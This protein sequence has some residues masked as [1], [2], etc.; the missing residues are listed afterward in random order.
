MKSIFIVRLKG[1]I[2]NQLF[3][4]SS[5]SSLALANDAFIIIDKDSGFLNDKYSR[6]YSI[7]SFISSSTFILPKYIAYLL[8]KFSKTFPR[9]AFFHYKIFYRALEKRKGFDPN[10]CLRVREFKFVYFDGYWQSYKYSSERESLIFN[11]YAKALSYY[12][13]SNT[14]NAFSPK[15]VAVHLRFFDELNLD[16]P[17][18]ITLQYLTDAVSYMYRDIVDPMFVIYTENTDLALR[19]CHKLQLSRYEFNQPTG[20]DIKELLH[21]SRHSNF[22][23]SNSTYGYWGALLSSSPNKKVIAPLSIQSAQIS[24]WLDKTDMPSTWYFI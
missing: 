8:Y 21:L 11:N 3:I 7:N 15:V 16:S 17:S 14:S 6:T 24:T 12:K 18:N 9:I 4:L 10:L 1:G 13:L 23:L 20:N 5:I 2:G 22:I 19:V